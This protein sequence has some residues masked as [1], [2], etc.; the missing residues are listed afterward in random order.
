MILNA[1]EGRPLP[2]YGK[3]EQIRDWLYVDD[4]AHALYQIVTQGDIGETYNVGGHNEK[5]NIEVV[6]SLCHLLEELAPEK[7][8]G[9]EY[10]G[11][12]VTF[13]DDRPGHDLRYAIDAGKI[14]RDLDWIPEE[15]FSTGLRKT[16]M[17]YL[18]NS[19]WC[20][21]V[22]DGSYRRE[23]LGKEKKASA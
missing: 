5:R 20:R 11:D 16:V 13:V 12:L 6:Q 8:V 18:D 9:V 7:P 23:R 1:L 21:H 4:H 14:Q 10:Y 3:G 2:V 17:W 15:T 22:Q 19:N